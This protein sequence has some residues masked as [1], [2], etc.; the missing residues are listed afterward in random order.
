MQFRTGQMVARR[1]RRR[2]ITTW[3]QAATVVAD[4]EDGLLLWQPMGAPLVLY[5]D[6]AGRSLKDVPIDELTGAS[7]VHS[8]FQHVSVLMW[9]P[10]GGNY[11]LWWMFD[12]DRFDCW[13]VNLEAPYQ[14]RPT[15][16]DTTDHALDLV[17]D[18]QR[19]VSWKDEPEF[20][21]RTG[22]PWY[23]NAA[24]AAEIRATAERL[25]ES[26]RA[27]RYPFDGTYCD[28]RPDPAWAMPR[29]PDG[30]NDDAQPSG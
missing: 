24:E 30:W 9:H 13:Y 8:T 5:Q 6:A 15:G 14:R 10:P 21:T 1:Y 4:D 18:P 27:G 3:A 23:W 20:V 7:L 11:S 19:T 2:H 22:H 17:I 26:A 12:G 29:L 16:I 28:F 25:A